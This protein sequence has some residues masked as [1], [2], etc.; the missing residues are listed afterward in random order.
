M[1][2]D[3][4]FKK[5]VKKGPPAKLLQAWKELYSL[6]EFAVMLGQIDEAAAI[7]RLLFGG[8]IA[9]P[10]QSQ[11]DAAAWADQMLA[12]VSAL[13][14]WPDFA[15]GKIPPMIHFQ[16]ISG[17]IPERVEQYDVA[18]R[19]DLS[20][21]TSGG[22]RDVPASA[23]EAYRDYVRTLELAHPATNQTFAARETEALA[24][25][26]TWREDW[27]KDLSGTFLTSWSMGNTCILAADIAARH[28]DRA[29]AVEWLHT[30]HV[31]ASREPYK[32]GTMHLF[33]LKSVCALVCDRVLA[34][35][36]AI[37]PDALHAGLQ[38]YMT[39]L[40]AM[41]KQPAAPVPLNRQEIS[42]SH[43][44]FYL[45]PAVVAADRDLYFQDM[46][47]SDQGFSVYPYKVAIGT[48]ADTGFV[49]VEIEIADK[50]P[51]LAR[52]K[53]AVVFPLTVTE[54]GQ[55]FLRSVEDFSEDWPYQVP[56]GNY[57]VLAR[58]FKHKA[59]E[60]ETG[61]EDAWRVVLT[62]MP[63]GTM[64]A[65]AIKLVDRQPPK[66]VFLHR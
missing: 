11:L 33:G 17:S 28:G 31:I 63:S 5:K 25:L 29:E 8:T 4:D 46:R 54:S 14:G 47:E 16:D 26:R 24:K 30:W 50:P 20:M 42:I 56:P 36:S 45:E 1:L 22:M 49:V 58:F 51:S 64:P 9:V 35:V 21:V 13:R 57:D 65:R 48:P 15:Q 39:K 62:F 52:V 19:K 53:Q 10:K 66:E 6:S 3:A 40:S 43:S 2:L 44:Q 12:G 55:L 61:G 60:E 41:L 38:S 59:T 7:W 18:T 37:T 34:D 23:S 32:F 27:A